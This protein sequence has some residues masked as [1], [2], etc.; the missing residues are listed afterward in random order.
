MSFPDSNSSNTDITLFHFKLRTKKLISKHL[1]NFNRDCKHDLKADQGHFYAY[2]YF[3]QVKD[4]SLKRGYFQKSFVIL[5]R[6][7][8][9][10]FFYE[11]TFRWAPLYFRNG[12]S[13]LESGF[14]TVLSWPNV[15]TNASFQLP[16]LGMVFQVFIPSTSNTQYV[17]NC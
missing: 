11:L 9:H 14:N 6:L 16:I 17:L 3:R 2:V 13:S 5:S 12:Q 10:N 15:S 4:S 1:I 8:F 7:P